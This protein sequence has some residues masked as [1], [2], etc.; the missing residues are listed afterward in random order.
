MQGDT[1]HLL[2]I[3]DDAI[4]RRNISVYFEDSGFVVTQACNGTEGIELFSQYHPDIV[5]V[6][7][8]MPETDGLAVVEH[9][10]KE[11][12][13]VPVIV[14][15]GVN[16]VD[17]AVKALKKGAWEF[18][19]KPIIEHGVL[20]HAVKKCLERA[21]LLL[22]RNQYHTLLESRLKTHSDELKT[23]NDQLIRY[24]QLLRSNSSFVN[25]L[26]EAIPSPL[27]ISD[28]NFVCIDCNKAFCDMLQLDKSDVVDRSIPELLSSNRTCVDV[29]CGDVFSN[30]NSGD[31][32]ITYINEDRTTSHYVLYRSA[33]TNG[34]DGKICTLG[35]L[36]NITELKAQKELVAH[37]AYHDELTSLPNRFH[38]VNFL[39]ELLAQDSGNT[40]FCLL[41]IDLD[42]FKRI[43]DSLGHDLGDQLLKL[44]AARLKKMIGNN[45]KVARV[46]GDEFLALLPNVTEE[47][48]IAKHAERLSSVFK[49]P[50]SVASHQ[51]H[52]SVTI[53]ITCYPDDGHDANTLLTRSDIAMYRAKEDKRSS[54]MRFDRCM[55]EQVT[56]RLKLERLIREG[57]ERREFIPYFQPRFDVQSGD[58]LGAEALVRWI[59]AD[60]SIGNPAEFIPV[61]EETGLIRE[62]GEHVLLDACKQ[63]H[64]WHEAG[65]V[66]LTISVNISAVQFTEDLYTTVSNAIEESGINPKK[67][68]LEITET[69]MMKNL[70]KTAQILRELAELGVKIVIDDFGTGYSSLYYLK[71]FPIDILKIDRSFI[72]G[73]PGDEHDGNIVSAILSMAKQMK[74]HVV[75]EGVETD[76]QLMFLQ[77]NNCEEAQGFLFSKPVA[78]DDFIHMLGDEK[79]A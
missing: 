7:L 60:G 11:A 20:D 53:G 18:I 33:F 30:N 76:E 2:I 62:L 73:I 59:R 61:A 46:G 23:T 66:D 64:A 26:V 1:L 78:A 4:L 27:Y 68:E 21:S 40:K 34:N 9:V 74:L 36:Y 47:G 77:Q 67:L 37:Q 54:W 58:I 63:M 14:I 28:K 38:I 10:K 6:D 52:L 56:E 22:E 45:G 3:D 12:P 79:T 13:Y 49:E 65:Y 16:L 43:N 29:L 17:E 32:E 48:V 50:F 24:Q 39:H 35:V 41:F 15:S 44:V 25:N 57:L 69:I 31:C 5:I 8:L 51:F 70:D 75:A 72:D 55:L 42:N 19:T 71:I